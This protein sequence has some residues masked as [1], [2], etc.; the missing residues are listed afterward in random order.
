MRQ[1]FDMWRLIVSTKEQSDS[2]ETQVASST[3]TM[4]LRSI[5]LTE[6]VHLE[7]VMLSE[8][9]K[10]VY[11]SGGVGRNNPLAFGSAFGS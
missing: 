2:D 6:I 5:L 4:Q 3:I 8:I 10:L 1:L 11:G 7:V 9:E